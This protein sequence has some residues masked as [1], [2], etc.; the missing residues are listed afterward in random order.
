MSINHALSELIFHIYIYI[1]RNLGS[2]CVIKMVFF[3]LLVREPSLCFGFVDVKR[4]SS[5]SFFKRPWRCKYSVLLYCIRQDS[6]ICKIHEVYSTAKEY[7]FLSSKRLLM[8]V[9]RSISSVSEHQ[10]EYK[11]QKLKILRSKLS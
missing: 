5:S 9:G 8:G 2:C 3:Q 4:L 7:I 10:P 6:V 11:Q 1:Y